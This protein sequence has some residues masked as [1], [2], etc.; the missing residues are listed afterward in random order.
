LPLKFI[1]TLLTS[2]SL[3]QQNPGS[4]QTFYGFSASGQ[5]FPVKQF[6]LMTVKISIGNPFSEK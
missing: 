3:S 6:L 1:K 4:G 5:T 2:L